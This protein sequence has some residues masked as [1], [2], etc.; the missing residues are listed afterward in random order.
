M[1]SD[2]SKNLICQR[3]LKVPIKDFAMKEVFEKDIL[4]KK[5]LHEKLPSMHVCAI[6]FHHYYL[7]SKMGLV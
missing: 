2:I 4:K 3:G 7:D 5:S 6:P 1:N